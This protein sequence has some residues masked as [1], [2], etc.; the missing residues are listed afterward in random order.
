MSSHRILKRDPFFQTMCGV[1]K[2][3]ATRDVVYFAHSVDFSAINALRERARGR[4]LR[5]PTYTALIVK[6]IG[7]ALRDC[8][9]VN[10]LV[11]DHFYCRRL[12]QLNEVH[13]AVAV[14]RE[15]EDRDM[16]LPTIIRNVD[17]QSLN[18]ITNVLC[19]RSTTSPESDETWQKFKWMLRCTPG[20]LNRL[21]IGIPGLWPSLWVKHHGGSFLITSPAKY[22]VET[23]LVK[24]SW[25]L[26]FSFGLVK[27]RPVAVGDRVEVR[28]T[29]TLSLAWDRR[30][31][32]G[33]VMARFFNEIVQRLEGADLE[34]ELC[35]EAA[36]TASRPFPVEERFAPVQ[37]A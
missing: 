28:P 12:V 13:A 25:P 30:L 15:E 5:P 22:G 4:G 34:D 29:S 24:I 10:R 21:F 1:I 26:A 3:W 9:K 7:L 17:R 6:A 32:T 27:R 35:G 2:G 36:D 33:A 8:P 16:A 11:M 18:G 37:T 31:T 23:I 19:D 20:W 14:E